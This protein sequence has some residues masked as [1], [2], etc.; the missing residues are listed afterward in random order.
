M[1]GA[2]DCLMNAGCF[3]DVS[4]VQSV[5]TGTKHGNRGVVA[6]VRLWRERSR[7]RRELRILADNAHLLKD[8]ALSRY[9]VQ[10]EARKPF[11]RG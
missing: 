5:T 1:S 8:V 9:D 7:Q 11:W 4:P 2:T 6:T 10:R 3:Q